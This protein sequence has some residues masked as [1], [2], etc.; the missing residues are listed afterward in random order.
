MRTRRDEPMLAGGGSEGLT[1]LSPP[2]PA[3]KTRY[4]I[5]RLCGGGT[6]VDGAWD[7]DVCVCFCVCL[8]AS[9]YVC[10]FICV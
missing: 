4:V 7:G 5:W 2:A 10:V 3:T 1:G 6:R 8:C 9:V